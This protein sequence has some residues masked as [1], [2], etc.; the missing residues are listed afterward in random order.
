MI[1]KTKR[2]NLMFD[3][4]TDLLIKKLAKKT[5]W[6]YCTLFIR[7]LEALIEKEGDRLK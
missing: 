7:A 2:Y 3:E 1:T 4:E 6:K 5:G